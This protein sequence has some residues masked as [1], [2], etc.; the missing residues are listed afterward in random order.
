VLTQHLMRDSELAKRTGLNL[1]NRDERKRLLKDW[2]TFQAQPFGFPLVPRE[3]AIL[4][5]FLTVQLL[6]RYTGPCG[7][8]PRLPDA[9][10]QPDAEWQP[11]LREIAHAPKGA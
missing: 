2:C 1:R 4:E 11:L 8:Y 6:P 3:V 9:E 10:G 5:C 7:E